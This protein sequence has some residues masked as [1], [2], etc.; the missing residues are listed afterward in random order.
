MS[1]FSVWGKGDFGI[2][3][4][5]LTGSKEGIAAL[6]IFTVVLIGIVLIMVR[7]ISHQLSGFYIHV[8]QEEEEQRLEEEREREKAA[9]EPT[10]GAL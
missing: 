6:V 8:S 5:A 7:L 4:D 2:I 1:I 10:E 9:A 3:R